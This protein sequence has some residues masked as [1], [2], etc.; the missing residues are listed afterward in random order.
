MRGR[1]Q[2]GGSSSTST[3]S[4][5]SSISTNPICSTPT[6][7]S[8]WKGTAWARSL[9][10]T[11]SV[12]SR[13][14]GHTETVYF[15]KTGSD[16]VTGTCA[17]DRERGVLD[18]ISPKPW[19]TDTC[20]GQW[21]YKEG[22]KYKSAKKV[23]D[24]LVD[25]VSKNGNLLLNFPLPAS[26]EPDAEELKTL[27]G[28]T[29]WVSVNGEGIFGTRPWKIYGEGPATKVVIPK[30]GKEFDPSEDKK[31]DLGVREV[32][33]TAK[34][35]TLYAL[36]QGWPASGSSEVI[37]EALGTNS[38]QQPAKAMDVR[39][40]GRDEALKFKQDSTGLRVTLPSTKPTAADMGICMK[41]N[42][43]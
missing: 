35:E 21:H 41:I 12:L 24:L 1:L 7:A 13:L 23:V 32:R 39:L 11:T 18:D 37:L 43:V 2:T 4:R 33:Y 14:S 6:A 10:P 31:P 42:F 36:V 34:G 19:Q 25:I 16:C 3:A 26:G 40:L 15:S 17:L 20:I 38:P 28:V 27:A 22:A 9:K 29:E 8:P 5:I 30:T